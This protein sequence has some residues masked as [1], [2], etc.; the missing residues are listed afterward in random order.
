MALTLALVAV[1]C[2]GGSTATPGPTASPTTV[3]VATTAA[4]ITTTT[5][6]APSTTVSPPTTSRLTTTPPTTQA[7]PT[8][9]APNP[10][11][12]P[13]TTTTPA[14]TTTVP[15]PRWRLLAEGGP[16]PRSNAA[17][18][19]DPTAG[20]LYLHGGRVGGQ[21]VGDLWAFDLSSGI[22]SEVAVQGPVPQARYSHSAVWDADRMRVI[23]TT[24]QLG[25]GEFLSDVWA[26]D[27]AVG[28]WELLAPDGAGPANR[29][30]SCA[31]YDPIRNRVL[32][33]HGFTDF[34]RFDDT[35]A[36]SLADGTW[37]DISPEGER[38]I[39][40]CLHACTYD[41]AAGRLVLM[42]GQTTGSR[43]LGDTWALDDAGWREI[44]D[45]SPGGRRFPTIAAVGGSVALF[46]GISPS[47]AVGEPLILGPATD[48]WIPID[49]GDGPMAR[50]SHA[51]AALGSSLFVLG[52]STADGESGDL[53]VLDGIAA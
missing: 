23:V 6:S 2:G 24:G 40:R 9:T 7:R 20:R 25:P 51:S 3:G 18:V 31:G 48:R 36:Y 28:E 21:A 1:A 47:G 44:P 43:I 8:T 46:G 34:G 13:T 50:H 53:W 35:W 37:T 5:T 39:E 15:L 17:L 10:T 41:A 52:G 19:V 33:S 27:P 26:F 32:V 45:E 16:G 30:G 29:Y 22:W 4:V 12:A 38:P 49:A 14:T 11:V 42:G